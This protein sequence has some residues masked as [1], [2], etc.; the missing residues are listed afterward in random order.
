MA[1]IAGVERGGS[2]LARIAFFLSRRRLG[3]VVRPLRIHALSSR[4][5]FGYGQME[6]AQLGMKRCP[7]DLRSLASVRVA[8]RVGCP[9]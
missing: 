9:F 2:L 1:R 4:L 6:Q 7:A 3:R 8:M 5:L